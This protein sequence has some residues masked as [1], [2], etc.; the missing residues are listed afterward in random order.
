MSS[1]GEAPLDRAIRKVREAMEEL[2]AY[3]GENFKRYRGATY[4]LCATAINAFYKLGDVEVMLLIAKAEEE[5]R[6]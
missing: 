4:R 5:R 2:T 3:L 6:G 1:T